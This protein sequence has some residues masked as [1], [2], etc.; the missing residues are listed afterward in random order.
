MCISPVRCGHLD[1][2][3]EQVHLFEQLQF[4]TTHQWCIEYL[5]DKT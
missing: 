4:F 1:I 2:S 5:K 3:S